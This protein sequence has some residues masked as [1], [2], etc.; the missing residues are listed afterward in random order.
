MSEV[1]LHR[2]AALERAQPQLDIATTISQILT[3]A[4]DVNVNAEK[5]QI[6]MNM[7]IQLQDRQAAQLFHE[8]VAR[9]QMRVPRISPH[10]EI[11]NKEKTE[12]RSRFAF[13]D[14]IDLFLR[15][16]LAEEGL[17][18]SFDGGEFINSK[19]VQT[20]FVSGYGHRDSRKTTM[21]MADMPGA[22]DPQK[23]GGTI[24]YAKRYAI[25][26]YFNII[27]VG[28]D[29]DAQGHENEALTAE[30]VGR[31]TDLIIG[32]QANKEKYL[33]FLKIKSL[34]ELKQGQFEYAANALRRKRK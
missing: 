18:V 24:S 7:V 8:A 31:L 34:E 23:M 21:P 22:S 14:D 5:A 13:Y 29:N 9:V 3:A 12:V 27:T 15:P 25:V 16:I 32:S 6:M 30:Q 1:E 28:V 10:G 33:N 20:M 4:G 19:L 11:L 26:Q 17:S 2:G